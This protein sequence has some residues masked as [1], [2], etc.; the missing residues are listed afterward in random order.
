VW[1][2]STSPEGSVTVSIRWSV[3]VTDKAAKAA[4][5][6]KH[7]I[8]NVIKVKGTA[9]PAE[10]KIRRERDCLRKKGSL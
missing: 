5:M 2:S 4:G 1:F 3:F 6:A 10:M 7:I 9:K 8:N